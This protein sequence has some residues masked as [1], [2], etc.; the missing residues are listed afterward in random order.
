MKTLSETWFVDGDID[1]ELKKYN[2]LGYLQEI[3]RYFDQNKLYP[4][5]AD[6][7]FHYNNLIAFK[8]NKQF[9][10]QQF[11][12]R[13]SKLDLD[14]L[15]VVYE[16]MVTDD[17]LMDELE[18][19][20]HYALDEMKGII[21]DGREIYD[22]VEEAMKIVPVGIMPLNNTEG[23]M[24]VNNGE[25]KEIRVYEYHITIFEKYHEK[26]RAMRTVF[27]DS[28]LRNLVNTHESIKSELL[29]Q[30]QSIPNPAV[31]GVVSVRTFPLEETFLPVAK[32]S[33]VKYISDRYE[34]AA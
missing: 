7:I 9:L 8:E 18:D 23:Y 24:F 26:Y 21:H 19:I 29:R 14:R 27:I 13:L 25:I 17:E 15:Q 32:R 31:Y 3:N 22:F 12:K 5:L 2:L 4:Q 28:W 1:F 16:K 6:L 33:L 34:G 10:Q 20:I 30:R 11:P